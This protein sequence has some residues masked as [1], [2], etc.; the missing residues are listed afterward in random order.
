RSI[1]LYTD[2]AQKAAAE[3]FIAKLDADGASGKIVTEVKPLGDFYDAEDYHQD[4]YAS[5]KDMPYCQIVINPKLELLKKK[6]DTL[7]AG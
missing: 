1:I 3:A 7:L 5:N 4:Y 2:D 6:F